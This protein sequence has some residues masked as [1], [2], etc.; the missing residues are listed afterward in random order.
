[1]SEEISERP[2]REFGALTQAVGLGVFSSKGISVRRAGPG[3]TLWEVLQMGALVGSIMGGTAGAYVGMI[4]HSWSGWSSPPVGAGEA[5]VTIYL[6]MVIGG[7]VAGG[8]AVAMLF[9]VLACFVLGMGWLWSVGNSYLARF[10][11]QGDDHGDEA[12][13][14]E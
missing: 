13:L 12:G 1:M 14:S 7:A 4:A 11:K 3:A 6:P 2:R 9:E 8:L 5:L 10:R